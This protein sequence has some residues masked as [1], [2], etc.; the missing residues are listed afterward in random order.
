MKSKTFQ[1][2]SAM[3]VAFGLIA[4]S[5]LALPSVSFAKEFKEFN[6]Q[7]VKG[8][9][10]IFLNGWVA[11]EASVNYPSGLV[12]T[13]S[14][15]VFRADGDGNLSKAEAT[16]NVGGFCIVHLTGSGTYSV[17]KNGTGSASAELS[18]QGKQGK[19]IPDCWTARRGGDS[20]KFDLNFAI[21][22]ETLEIVGTVFENLKNQVPVD[23]PF[24]FGA[25][26]QARPQDTLPVRSEADYRTEPLAP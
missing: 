14:V 12:P 23:Y 25:S 11:K 10:S 22:T 20:M 13:W 7:S 26:G 6:N 4:L 3:T 9:Y 15:G 24:R 19:P 17:N 1:M 21:N 5:S 18:V 16:L 2:P 8:G